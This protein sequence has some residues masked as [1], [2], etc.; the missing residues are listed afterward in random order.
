[1]ASTPSPV[2]APAPKIGEL[3]EKALEQRRSLGSTPSTSTLPN[4][5]FKQSQLRSDRL[6]TRSYRSQA[7]LSRSRKGEEE[8][9]AVANEL[10]PAWDPSHYRYIPPALKGCKPVT[11][12]PW[13]KDEANYVAGLERHGF[14]ANEQ[15]QIA[16]KK[17]VSY[18]ANV[19]KTIEA[20]MRAYRKELGTGRQTP[21]SARHYRAWSDA[22]LLPHR[23]PELGRSSRRPHALGEFTQTGEFSHQL[24]HRH[25]SAAMPT[26]SSTPCCS[27]ASTSSARTAMPQHSGVPQH[28]TAPRQCDSLQ[29]SSGAPHG[30]AQQSKTQH[31]TEA[32][33]SRNQ[34]VMA[35]LSSSPMAL[36]PSPTGMSAPRSRANL[37]PSP[38]RSRPFSSEA[39][40]GRLSMPSSSGTRSRSSS[41]ASPFRCSTSGLH[42]STGTGTGTGTGSRTTPRAGNRTPRAGNRTPRAAGSSNGRSTP[43]G[44]RSNRT[45]RGGSSGS[46]QTATSGCSVASRGAMCGDDRTLVTSMRAQFAERSPCHGCGCWHHDPF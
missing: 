24:R 5:T 45:P 27:N 4:D 22:G 10:R 17:Q 40:V 8:A 18:H 19:A 41:E 32:R 13:A 26:S 42:Q 44:S 6:A 14:K 11:P 3:A 37:E 7:E 43:R 12:E 34:S 28:S 31:S 29:Q 16:R 38:A 46:S 35:F 36:P 25:G 30:L 23:P 9:A 33:Q 20:D 2:D 1:M 39:A 15:N 21:M